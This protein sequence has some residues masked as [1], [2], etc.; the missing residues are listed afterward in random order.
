M[1]FNIVMVLSF[2]HFLF[3]VESLSSCVSFYFTLP[4]FVSFPACFLCSPVFHLLINLWVIKSAFCVCSP[5][6]AL[7]PRVPCVP[8]FVPPWLSL[9]ILRFLFHSVV[10][11][12]ILFSL[13][14]LH[15]YLS[16]EMKY[17][18]CLCVSLETHLPKFSLLFAKFWDRH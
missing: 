8:A 9:L 5:G 10:F 3:Y 18:Q 4:V 15:L 6:P 12:W 17:F 2:G 16:T 11:V 14:S 1:P 13:V 7:A